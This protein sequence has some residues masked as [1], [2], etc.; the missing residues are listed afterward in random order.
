MSDN[1]PPP[2][3][4]IAG[5]MTPR[6]AERPRLSAVAPCLAAAWRRAVRPVGDPGPFAWRRERALVNL[7][8]EQAA[9]VPV[10]AFTALQGLRDAGKVQPGQKVLVIG[11]AGGVGSFAV[12]IAKAFGAEVTGVC[13]TSKTDLVRSIGAERVIDYTREDFAA[14]LPRYDVIL[15]AAGNRPLSHLRR[16]LTPKGTLVIIGGEGGGPWL[17]G[18]DKGGPRGAEGAHRGR[19]GR[20]G[21]RQDLPAEPGPRSDPVSR[22]RAPT[23]EGRRHRLAAAVPCMAPR[24]AAPPAT[25]SPR[26]TVAWLRS[27]EG[28]SLAPRP[29]VA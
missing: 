20:A 12:Q 18:V 24:G 1:T 14:A 13:S 22:A 5:A 27:N 28:L 26:R 19:Q 11:A 2:T 4:A 29:L 16:A 9:A 23:G 7:T 17:G 21:D 3:W 6:G 8:F 25:A 15:D 10:S